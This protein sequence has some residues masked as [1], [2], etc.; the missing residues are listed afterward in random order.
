[1]RVLVAKLRSSILLGDELAALEPSRRRG[2]S[3]LIACFRT[4]ATQSTP[5][6]PEGRVA[7]KLIQSIS[8]RGSSN[9][10]LGFVLELAPFATFRCS[11]LSASSLLRP[12]VI[13]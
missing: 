4:F 12:C 9:L 11:S 5:S 1:M 6:G 7:P 10:V 2:R 3:I 8:F 13:V